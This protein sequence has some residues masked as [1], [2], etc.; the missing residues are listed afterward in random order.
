MS[1][2]IICCCFFWL[3]VF[4]IIVFGCVADK[5]NVETDSDGSNSTYCGYDDSNS[6]C[7]FTIVVG[8]LAFLFC[9]A[10]LVKDVF[11]VIIDYSNTIVVSNMQ[12]SSNFDKE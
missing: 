4:S 7:G 12:I 10:F 1:V 2:I 8:V 9:F 5:G 6:Y 3:Q 11:Y